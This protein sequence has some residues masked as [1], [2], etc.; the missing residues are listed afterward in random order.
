MKTLFV[1]FNKQLRPRI[2]L[3]LAILDTVLRRNGHQTKIFDTSFYLSLQSESYKNIYLSGATRISKDLFGINL[4]ITDPIEDLT[5]LIEEFDPDILG[6]S[7]YSINED[8]HDLIL[9]NVKKRFPKLL[10]LTGGPAACISPKDCLKKEYI[11][12]VCVGEGE[13]LVLDLARRIDGGKNYD[14]IIG[15]WTKNN[16]NN[17]IA[18]IVDLNNMPELDYD[19]FDPIQINGVFNGGLYRMGHI[20]FT[21]GC[22]YNCSYCGSGSIMRTYRD[23]G[24]RGFVRHKD[25][26]LAIS[27]YSRLKN[28]YNLDM[29]YFVDGTF[30]AMS[31][32]TLR[33][34]SAKYKERVG[35]PFIALVRPESIR[36]ETAKL[37]N[38]MGCKHVSIGVESG[39]EEYRKKILNRHMTNR[40][41]IGAIHSL[42][43]EGIGVTAYNMIGLPGMDRKHVFKTIELNKIA[44]PQSSV[45]GIFI[46]YADNELT[47]L[48]IKRGLINGSD[49]CVGDGMEP[50]VKIKEMSNKEIVG[51]F[52]TFN[53]YVKLPKILYAAIR[54]LEAN[55]W[56]IKKI[57]KILYR[58]IM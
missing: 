38:E 11:D 35:I 32:N 52:N 23:S 31:T 43:N 49:I 33:E 28:K 25:V 39:V 50:S 54:I 24:Q 21:R 48:L 7:N 14:D 26:D 10:I 3:S 15:L 44:K 20:E 37:L 19:S 18:K 51:L 55:N 12:M 30:T 57:R 27:E 47:K 1:Y 29:F 36:K 9:S 58:I 6:F 53:L 46:P 2:P 5:K 13:G 17:G 8:M 34:L 56:I 22:P 16:T 41:I 40:Q 45:V 42:K 4:K